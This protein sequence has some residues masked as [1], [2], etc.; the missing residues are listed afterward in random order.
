MFF[1]LCQSLAIDPRLPFG[2]LAAGPPCSLFIWLS[3]SVHK[4]H[5][6]GPAGD[7]SVPKVALANIITENLAT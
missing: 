3:C 2:M 1:S 6:Y 4:R 5:L 7:Q